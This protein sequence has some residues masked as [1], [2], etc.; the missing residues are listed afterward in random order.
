[1][2]QGEGLGRQDPELN[3]DG[4][5]PTA[6]DRLLDVASRLQELA[7]SC[8]ETATRQERV[9]RLLTLLDELAF[10]IAQLPEGSPSASDVRPALPDYKAMR[11]LVSAGCPELGRYATV[12]CDGFEASLQVGDAVDDLTDILLDLAEIRRRYEASGA[13]EAAWYARFL[14]RAHF[15]YHLV[16]VR[17][18]LFHHLRQGA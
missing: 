10:R 5:R 17:R 12:P 4:D 1:M 13:E 3:A 11:A 9:E 2:D 18:A 14:Y 16:E 7:T 15:G 6:L 8:S